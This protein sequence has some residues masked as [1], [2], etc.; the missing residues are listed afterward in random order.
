MLYRAVKINQNLST[1]NILWK[2][3]LTC[4]IFKIK[5]CKLNL[6]LVQSRYT[7]LGHHDE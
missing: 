5:T 3:I 1:G 4:N 6:N 2:K 7:F